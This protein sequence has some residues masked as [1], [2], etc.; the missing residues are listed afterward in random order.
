M[1][2]L[3]DT[4]KNP[5]ASYRG[6]PF[7]SWNNKLDVEQLTRQ[8]GYFQK[9]GF[10][11]VMVHT[12]TG[13]DTKYLG[14]EF[15]DCVGASVK[16][17][18]EL[19]MT[20]W[21]Y[22]ED[23]WPSGY[24]GGEVTR[25]P[26]FRAR[27]LL[28]T[29]TPYCGKKMPPRNTSQ[30]VA[31]RQ[32]NGQLMA[33]YEIVLEK[34]FLRSYRRLAEGETVS[35]EG[36]EWFVYLE[37]A[38]PIPW[39][40]DQPYV[41]TLNKGAMEYFV[42]TSYSAYEKRF[43]GEFG[44][45][46]PAIF[47]DEP[48]HVMK[49][50]LNSPDDLTDQIL[51]FTGDFP[52]T[53]FSVTGKDFW[54]TVPEI[55][56]ER[57]DGVFSEARYLFHDHCTERFVSAFGDTLG[58]W[59]ERH[60]IQVVGHLMEEQ[61]LESQTRA[62][63]EVMRFL[64][65]F[66]IPGID[67]LA[68]RVEF[69]TA[70]QAVSVARQYGRHDVMSEL[71]GVTGWDFDFVGHKRQGDWQAALGI[72]VRVPH[73]AWVSMAGEAKR[74][75]PASIFYQS[76]W[77]LDYK[78]VE[79]YF[80][81]VKVCL[82]Q[83]QALVRVGVIH[84]VESL[85][86]TYGNNT[87]TGEIRS[88]LDANYENLS[89]WLIHGLVD[90]DF[91]SE[92]L[93]PSQSPSV[94]AF[95]L[96][97]GAMSYQAVIVPSL[98]TIRSTTLDALEKLI[99]AGGTVIFTGNIPRYVDARPSQR[100]V[101]LAN[102]ALTVSF[103]PTSLLAA[104]ESFRELDVETLQGERCPQ[105]ISQIRDG[106]DR[107][108]V[109]LANM[110]RTQ[111]QSASRIRFRG[112]WTVTRMDALDGSSTRLSS[113][114]QDGFTAINESILPHGSAL[115]L[116]NKGWSEGGETVRDQSFTEIARL[117]GPT[118]FQLEE[119]NV[120]LLD[121]AEWKVN[122]GEWQPK[123]EIL[124]IENLVR[125]KLGLDPKTGDNEQPWSVPND[126]QPFGFVFLRYEIQCGVAI[127]SPQLALEHAD[128]TEIT[129]DGHPVP[130]RAVGWYVDEAIQKVALPTMSAGRHILMLRLP[131][132]LRINLE[133]VYLLGDF[134]VALHGREACL[135]ALPNTL[136]IGDICNQGFPFYGGNFLYEFTYEARGGESLVEFS[137]FKGALISVA[138][139]GGEFQPTAFAPFQASLGKLSPGPHF[140]TVKVMGNRF[141]TFG[142]LHN[143]I[144]NDDQGPW[145]W[146]TTGKCWTYEYQTRPLGLLSAP[147]I[148]MPRL[149]DYI[150]V[151][152]L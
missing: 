46:I 78:L 37:V 20:T 130:N 34:G 126:A 127:N 36:F 18:K 13:L 132:H 144:P 108:F 104:L 114:V 24:A 30:S 90:F 94:E 109:F 76:P 131:Y 72:T 112:E 115:Y 11:G 49:S 83:G 14:E 44:K 129:L 74:D 150:P 116:L 52:E 63:G 2:Q 75:Y 105:L 101:E 103:S 140:I 148:L 133:A 27:Y 117:E 149:E 91:I 113:V 28:L 39:F 53:Y 4:F 147:R 62:V 77:Y 12:R 106:G 139:D 93:L 89:Q 110:N 54:A 69:G 95:A 134:G 70:K 99:D 79:D 33:R 81:R 87:Q 21:L 29:R 142:T 120:L 59:C 61:T 45:A 85:W 8:I 42:G 5:P 1:S 96:R 73:L 143:L 123:E 88:E 19:G 107:R 98:L 10:G 15:M 86:V 138:L 100:A 141:N 31:T 118:T 16:R 92:S 43:G 50:R 23:R 57:R 64:R 82:T 66:Q 17:A 151:S 137:L 68:D 6:V 119:P 125:S 146:R 84:P 65:T 26:E 97:V 41:D 47:T 152:P 128:V 3:A 60:G 58:N 135:V 40:N 9:M 71:Y 145:A 48:Q 122:E 121:Q 56:W 7:W 22:D 80:A 124:R 35:A 67:M 51:P 111:G 136:D 55:F 102:A 38:P 25:H 32:E